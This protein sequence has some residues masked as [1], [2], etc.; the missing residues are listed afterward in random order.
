MM[1]QLMEK[2]QNQN[3]HPADIIYDFLVINKHKAYSIN[4]LCIKF[5]LNYGIIK[6]GINQLLKRKMIDYYFKE[7]RYYTY[8][9]KEG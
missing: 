9:Y 6:R 4:Q 5:N 7:P 1:K 2:T 3:R 8:F